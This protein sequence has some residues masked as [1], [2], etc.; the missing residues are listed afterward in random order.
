MDFYVEK[1]NPARDL[2]GLCE[3]FVSATE[4]ARIVAPL[5]V[6]SYFELLYC[7]EGSY[8]LQAEHATST[9][10]RGGVAL[11]HPMEPH[12]TRALCAGTN[13]YLVLKFMPEALYSASQPLYELKYIL[14]YLHFSDRRRFVYGA[15]QLRGSDLEGL[16]FRILEE[17]QRQ[18]YGYE[19]ALRAYISQVL[20]W[21]LRAWN[22]TREGVA[23]DERAMLRLQRAAEWIDGHLDE[24][25]RAQDAADALGM[26]LSTF[27]RFFAEAAGMSFPAYVRARR[28]NRAAA[29]LAEGDR[30]VTEIALETGFSTASYLILCFR[31]QY[32]ITPRRFRDLY[33]A[34]GEERP[35]NA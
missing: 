9:L 2:G 3:C 1:P 16:L 32:G 35:R 18:E 28:L 31:Q 23:I 5:H 24:P 15:E 13:R 27:S 19:M 22:R 33:A 21:F 4:Q 11:I 34:P 20:L 30:S 8:E 14:P 29:L 26:G 6:H 17:R 10:N 25:L 7:L 12:Q